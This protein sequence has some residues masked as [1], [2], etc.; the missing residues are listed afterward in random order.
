MPH[1][2]VI[3]AQVQP[4]KIDEAIRVFRDS[5]LPVT[6]QQQGARQLLLLA[7]RKANRCVVVGIWE[8]EQ[9]MAASETS[10]YFQL[11][12]AKFDHIFAAPP[13]RENYDVVVAVAKP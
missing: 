9:A 11:Q 4:G 6:G 12:A 1:A 13:T 8:S 2:R 3:T 5:V 7:D 10:G